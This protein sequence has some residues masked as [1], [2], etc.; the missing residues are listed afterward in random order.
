MKHVVFLPFLLF[1][2]LFSSYAQWTISNPGQTDVFI[3]NSGQYDYLL[4]H[5]SEPISYVL[6]SNDKH[7]FFTEHGYTIR[8]YKKIRKE[9]AGKEKKE[10]ENKTESLYISMNWEGSNAHPQLL[11][12]MET[13]GYHSYADEGF[14]NLKSKGYKKLT[15]KELY[16][17]I[18]ME[19][20]I[21]EEGG[22][23]YC[24]IAQPAAD[25]SKIKM[26][27][28]GDL[29]KIETDAEGNI[30]IKT[31]A[32]YIKVQTPI[33]DTRLKLNTGTQILSAAWPVTPNLGGGKGPYDV[34]F[35]QNGNVYIDYTDGV[36]GY[37]YISKYSPA[38]LFQWTIDLSPA[39]PASNGSKCYADFCVIPSGSI[40][41]ATGFDTSLTIGGMVSK[42]ST[43]GS[44]VTTATWP[45]ALNKEG[46]VINY[47]KCSNVLLIGGGGTTNY[48]SMRMGIDTSLAGTITGTNFNAATGPLDCADQLGNPGPCYGNDMAR[49]LIDDNGDMYSYFASNPTMTSSN[50]IT[51]S[52]SPYNTAVYHTTRA[53]CSFYE[54]TSIPDYVNGSEVGVCTRLNVMDMNAGYLYFFDGKNL[55]AYTK[56]N[57]TLI[58]S[59]I[60]SA[61]YTCGGYNDF[62]NTGNI[63]PVYKN[64][65]IAVDACNNIYVGGQS[66][67]HEFNFNG[68]SF[69]VLTTIPVPANVYDLMLDKTNHLLYAVGNNF[70]SSIVV[71]PCSSISL[72]S[73]STCGVMVT[74]PVSVTVIGGTPPYTYSWSNG[75]S[76]N[77]MTAVP[78]TYSVTVS[79]ASCIQSIQTA[80]ILVPAAVTAATS[81]IGTTCD[82]SNGQASVT[83]GGGTGAYT[84]SWSGGASSQT[85]SGLGA[86]IY[87]VTVFDA[88][89]CTA[90]SIATVSCPTSENEFLSSIR[91]VLFP[92]PANSIITIQ[93]TLKDPYSIQLINLL[94]E[95]VTTHDNIHSPSFN[96]DV[97]TLAKSVYIVQVRN[98]NTNLIGRQ[99]VVLE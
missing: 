71:S 80:V 51:K 12:E 95:I 23:R 75:A 32:G 20:K 98:L 89:N 40:F 24:L 65:G 92:N 27:Y 8:L 29:E 18:D 83:A 60:V 5:S 52:A 13:P 87:T 72:S 1:A 15:Y 44:L 36:K 67:I 79:D 53:G 61:A 63:N 14:R 78:G 9:N 25:L 11:A 66:K 91:F 31:E 42:I 3:K 47:N 10:E 96:L 46:W 30:S 2:G 16:P 59:I 85:I 86:G 55:E 17:G 90:T 37:N 22:I 41:I 21:D 38:G 7:V 54:L 73:S 6:N 77:P 68:T 99:R 74:G 64:E 43:A 35:D 26:H 88:D 56:S 81:S 28:G 84:Y 45:I 62:F 34:A 50:Q 4:G 70:V 19:F 82:N 49:M 97:A 76:T 69:T 93:T 33:G 57:G 94:G 58:A 48:V 39:G